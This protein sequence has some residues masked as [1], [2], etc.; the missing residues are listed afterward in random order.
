MS[1]I[2]GKV[3]SD[4]SMLVRSLATANE[5]N[6]IRT[7]VDALAE[8]FTR[9]SDDRLDELDETQLLITALRRAGAIDKNDALKLQA[10]YLAEN[11]L[12]VSPF[13]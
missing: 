6:C 12:A 10:A 8:H 9:L 7:P 13:P 3:T 2:I 11:R 5:V 1:L 4:I